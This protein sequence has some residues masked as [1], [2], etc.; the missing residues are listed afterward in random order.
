MAQGDTPTPK[1]TGDALVAIHQGGGDEVLGLVGALMEQNRR[2]AEWTMNSL[3]ESEK[4]AHEQTKEK[5][6]RANGQ[7]GLIRHRVAWLLGEVDTPFP[8]YES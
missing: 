2:D 5:L 8:E 6:A 1:E 7:L 4:F 3:Y